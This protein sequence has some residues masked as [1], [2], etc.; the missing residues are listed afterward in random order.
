MAHCYAIGTIQKSER[1]R[2]EFRIFKGPGYRQQHLFEKAQTH[3]SARVGIVDR[4]SHLAVDGTLHASPSRK[5]PKRDQRLEEPSDQTA[6][7]FYDDDEVFE[8]PGGQIR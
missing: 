1:H 2:A 6:D 3:R 7:L 5:D 4:T 8:H